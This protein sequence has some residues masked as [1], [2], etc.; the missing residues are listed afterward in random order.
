MTQ[1]MTASNWVTVAKTDDVREGCLT[2]ADAGF[3]P[4]IL[5]RLAD[6][7]VCV[8]GTCPHAGASL[9]DGE[10]AGQTITCPSHGSVFDVCSGQVLQAP[11]TTGLPTYQV[12]VVDGDVQIAS[13]KDKAMLWTQETWDPDDAPDWVRESYQQVLPYVTAF[14]PGS[15]P[16]RPGPVCP[17][18][19]GAL[20]RDRISFAEGI[21]DGD[22]KQQAERLREC[23]DAFLSRKQGFS[24]LL[25]LLP[26]DYDIAALSETHRL[27]KEY[28]VR[29]Q[30]MLGALWPTNQAPSL[31]SEDYFPLRTPVPTLVVRDMVVGD[32][33]FLD[34]DHYSIFR[35]L[36]FLRVFMR[37]FREQASRSGA[38]I[39]EYD[40]ARNLARH[41]VIQI[42]LRVLAAAGF[43]GL[44]TALAW[45]ARKKS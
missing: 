31:H 22:A 33:R 30:L 13:P 16:Y 27:M 42:T 28:C 35:R 45:R 18:V 6:S 38:E 4:L 24:A 14:L 11:A 1:L 32:L 39:T 29:R 5:T 36:V 2:R 10:L 26:E 19:P 3:G 34:P 23:V 43:T 40:K 8:G 20:R 21:A 9:E 41:Y 15:H 17:F 37:K 25:V 7:F 44:V 12:R